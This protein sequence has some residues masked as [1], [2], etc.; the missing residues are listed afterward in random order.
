MIYFTSSLIFTTTLSVVCENS[1]YRTIPN[2]LLSI[3]ASLVIILLFYLIINFK[4]N[5]SIFEKLDFLPQFLYSFINVL[6]I[7][8]TFIYTVF[9][10]DSTSLFINL[11]YLTNMHPSFLVITVLALVIYLN[12]KGINTIIKTS[13]LIFYTYFSLLV[14]TILF[15]FPYLN[16]LNVLPIEMGFDFKLIIFNSLITFTPLLLLLII[17]KQ[18][19][20]EHD[21][22]NKKMFIYLIVVISLI[23]IKTIFSI[24]ILSYRYISLTTYPNI[25]IFKEIKLLNFLER[26]EL[27]LGISQILEL[28]ITMSFSFNYIKDGLIKTLKPKKDMNK[29]YSYLIGLFIFLATITFTH[30]D[31][32]LLCYSLIT[33]VITHVVISFIIFL[34]KIFT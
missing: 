26:I 34:H 24:S 23:I 9:L 27:I 30:I 7:I 3:V 28:F 10:I 16:I 11:N 1:I 5:K 29:I 13:T 2:I 6:L 31:N 12:T 22:T 18:M 8:T 15:L 4:P 32:T 25:A 17:P 21:K 19:I 20:R 14:I 33:F